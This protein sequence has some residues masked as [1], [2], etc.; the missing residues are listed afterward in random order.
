[1]KLADF[2]LLFALSLGLGAC[3]NLGSSSKIQSEMAGAW[4]SADGQVLLLIEGDRCVQAQDS[5]QML[6]GLRYG[7]KHALRT[8]LYLGQPVPGGLEF[9]GETLVMVDPI[10][11][12]DRR[13]ERLGE[14]PEALNIEPFALGTTP[15]SEAR[16]Q[17]IANGLEQREASSR[18][19]RD[20]IQ[21]SMESARLT[22][23]LNSY[24]DQ[25][26]FMASPK[27]VGLRRQLVD[28]DAAN[29]QHISS[30]LRQ[31]GWI[32]KAGYGIKAQLA[33]FNMVRFGGNLQV[34]RSVL[35]ALEAELGEDPELGYLYTLLFDSTQLSL[36]GKQLYGTILLP[37]MDGKMRM[38][39]VRD[40]GSL[41]Q[42]RREMGLP[43]IAEFLANFERR[44]GPIRVED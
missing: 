28:N 24:E 41:D 37:D 29:T 31:S 22:G 25:L 12:Q 39:R 21:G 44:L 40:K 27:M 35:P 17:A 33:A 7:S 18:S 32:T 14:T 3:A 10:R 1:M 8:Q 6:F 4:E 34:M 23:Q 42:R 36:G 43:P 2:A 11:G 30:L 16:R 38:R 5:A 20:S 26:S 15:P 9:E 19:I 13:F